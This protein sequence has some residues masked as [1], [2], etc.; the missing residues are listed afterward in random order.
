MGIQ[1]FALRNFPITQ[2]FPF[3]RFVISLRLTDCKSFSC[4]Y[5][6]RF[7]RG[8]L[9]YISLHREH[10]FVC[11]TVALPVY[12]EACSPLMFPVR[13]ESCSSPSGPPFLLRLLAVKWPWCVLVCLCGF[14]S[15]ESAGSVLRWLFHFSM[16]AS[17]QMRGLF[18]HD[19][20]SWAFT[21]QH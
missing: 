15:A 5:I 7:P 6:C 9:R 16:S 18:L 4:K 17:D 21:K 12:T 13:H 11:W 1:A 2:S 20:K 3:R 8:S 14:R 10:I 19:G